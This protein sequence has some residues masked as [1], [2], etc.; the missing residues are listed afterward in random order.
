MVEEMSN[1]IGKNKDS[2]WRHLQEG[3]L[4]GVKVRSHGRGGFWLI[5]PD[6]YDAFVQRYQEAHE[7]LQ[8]WSSVD[9]YARTIGLS[10]QWVRDLIRAGRIQADK[11]SRVEAMIVTKD[12]HVYRIP[13]SEMELAQRVQQ[14]ITIGQLLDSLEIEGTHFSRGY[15]LSTVIPQ[16]GIERNK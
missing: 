4:Q 15:I 11:I 1:A 8:Q 10:I 2:I 12:E 7:H 9:T 16:L 13:P 6:S 5:A 3:Y 14:M